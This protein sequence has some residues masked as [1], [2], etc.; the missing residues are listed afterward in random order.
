M[1]SVMTCE[2]VH[3][4]RRWQLPNANIVAP[5]DIGPAI[6]MTTRHSV[7]ASSHHR[8]AFGMRDQIDLFRSVAR[9][10]KSLIDR[11]WHNPS[12]HLPG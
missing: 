12:G 2:S 9:K 3:S 5:F 6:L 8:N 7:L 4:V 10:S 11:A 1:G